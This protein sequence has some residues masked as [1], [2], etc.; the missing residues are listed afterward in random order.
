MGVKQPQGGVDQPPPSTANVRNEYTLCVP[1]IARYGVT[2]TFTIPG[3]FPGAGGWGQGMK[4][5]THLHLLPRL[6]TIGAIPVLTAYTFTARTGTALSSLP[7]QWRYMQ[8]SIYSCIMS[9]LF[10][11]SNQKH[12]DTTISCT[13]PHYKIPA[14]TQQLSCYTLKPR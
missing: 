5:H 3:F 12:G 7:P 6:R 13:I 4:L 10:A 9:N 8:K 1:H 11:P 14:T 2:F